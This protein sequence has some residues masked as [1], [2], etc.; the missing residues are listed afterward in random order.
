MAEIKENATPTNDAPLYS[1]TVPYNNS[2]LVAAR[3]K[4]HIAGGLI[5]LVAALAM[6]ALA[7]AS[8]ITAD[9]GDMTIW[10]IILA[11]LGVVMLAGAVYNFLHLKPS[12]RDNNKDV[13][14][15]F[16]D[17]G[18]SVVRNNQTTG[19]NKSLE[20]CLYRSAHNKQ[21]VAKIYDYENRLEFKIRTGSYNGA[22]QYSV[23]ILPKDVLDAAQS[24]AL[25]AFLQEQVG[26]DYVRK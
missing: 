21:Y 15:Q 2:F 17:Y 6:A 24:S 11:V 23:Q 14:L 9:G 5:C 26:K 18:M 3:K 16:F 25:L 1:V 19:K 10:V 22:P 12:D 20:R 7:I 8:V 4:S 13:V